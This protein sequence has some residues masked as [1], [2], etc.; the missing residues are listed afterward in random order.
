MGY[1][2]VSCHY[3]SEYQ[4]HEKTERKAGPGPELMQVSST[5]KRWVIFPLRAKRKYSHYINEYTVH[6]QV[7]VCA[8]YRIII[9]F[10]QNK[11]K[12]SM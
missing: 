1:L 8:F 11:K 4:C 7:G 10:F 2:F 12:W 3:T 9:L 5:L 6:I